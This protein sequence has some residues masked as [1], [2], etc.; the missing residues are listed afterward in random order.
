MSQSDELSR[1]QQDLAAGRLSRRA[2]L[3]RAAA[4]G[5]A[6][7]TALSLAGP[8]L[9]QTPKTGGRFVMAIGGG[10]TSD[11]L[12]P[13]TY[14]ESYMQTLGYG[15]R[16]CLAE[17]SNLDELQPELA[18]SWEASPDAATWTVKLRKGVEFHSGKTFDADDAIASVQHHLG[19]ESKSAA[20]AILSS[21]EEIKKDDAHTIVFKLSGGNVGFP[22]LLTDYHVHML[23]LKDGKLDT[24][25]GDG[26]GAFK[27]Q[28]FEAGQRTTM[29]RNPNYW[30]AGNGHFDEVAVL[31]ITDVAA[32]TNALATGEVH[33]ADRLDLKTL[34]LL[35]RREGIDIKDISGS[36]WYGFPMMVDREPYSNPDL[37]LALKFAIDREELLS[38]LL[39]GHGSV[40]NDNPIGKS[41]RFYAE[42]P[43][44][45]FDIDK[46]KFHLKKSGLTNPKVELH[47]ADAA[48]AGAVDAGTLFVESAKKCGIDMTVTRVPNDG[49]WSNV[50]RVVPWSATYWNPRVTEDMMF[51]SAISADAP[52]N[53]S[54]WKDPRFNQLLK[55]AR[56][57]F[58]IDKRAEMYR[59]M[60]QLCTEEN[61]YIIPLFANYV[62]ATSDEIAHDKI[63][64]TWDLDG[65]KCLERWWFA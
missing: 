40:A 24:M 46:A 25:S 50:N 15:L 27:L 7:P 6:L 59:E 36:Q 64:T 14:Y 5:V 16:N 30:K 52:W 23:P 12:D 49:Y 11:T 38:K 41:Y 43:Q 54:N 51:S 19:P 29:T 63:A 55:E 37:R 20:K 32:R 34:R 1:Y 47:A 4:L 58:D 26:T 60:Q 45:S 48:F 61:G 33:A 57:E 21:I 53:E 42:L 35:R 31:S 2:F 28:E 10:A 65:T 18:E 9:S 13:A 22:A 39:Y 8:A 62:F 44:H 17:M 3:G 56:T